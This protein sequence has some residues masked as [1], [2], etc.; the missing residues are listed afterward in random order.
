MIL[1]EKVSKLLKKPLLR[2]SSIK[3]YY[4]LLRKVKEKKVRQYLH[5]CKRKVCIKDTPSSPLVTTE[6]TFY[7]DKALP[8]VL[9][10][11]F[12]ILQGLLICT[13]ETM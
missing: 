5:T 3:C 13:V 2:I 11:R 8:I 4:I 12:I 1:P 10:L 6:L 7:N 9:Q